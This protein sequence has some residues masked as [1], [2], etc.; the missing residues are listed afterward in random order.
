MTYLTSAV[1]VAMAFQ[2]RLSLAAGEAA[3]EACPTTGTNFNTTAGINYNICPGTDYIGQSSQVIRKINTVEKCAS[4]C[5]DNGRC[6]KATYD[7]AGN[8]CHIKSND[9]DLTWTENKKFDAIYIRNELPETTDIATCPYKET[10]YDAKS[11]DEYFICPGTDLRGNDLQQIEKVDSAT[12]C[13]RQCSTIKACAKAV[14]DTANKVCHVKSADDQNRNTLIWYTNKRYSTIQ[15]KTVYNPATRGKWS[16]LIRLPLI[17]VAAY[18]VPAFPAPERML[19]FSSFREF[20]FTGATGKTQFGDLNLNTGEV[21]Q[22]EVANTHHDMFCPAIATLGDGRIVVQGGS[23][24]EAVS[25]YNPETNEFTRGPNMTVAR[26]YQASCTLSDGRIFTIGGSYSGG[27]GGKNGE[28]FDADTNEWTYLPGAGVEAMLTDDVAGIWRKD[29][30]GW[31]LGWKNGTVFQAGP[32]KAQNWYGTEGRGSS[33]KA[34][35]RDDADAMCGVWAMYDAMAG[36]IFSAVGTPD[37]TDSDANNRAHITT[38]G[39]PWEPSTVERMPDPAYARGFANAVVLPDGTILVTGGQKRSMVFTDTDGIMY[40]EL[41]DPARRTWAQ[42]APE[43]VPR[44]YHS[45]SILLPDATVFSGGGGLC[46][47]KSITADDSGC[48]RTVDHPDGQIFSPP[49]LFNEDGSDATRPTIDALSATNA[50][51]GATI[52]VV[53]QNEEVAG[54]SSLVLVRLGSVTHST[55]TD[56]RRVPLL[57]VTNTGTQVAGEVAADGTLVDFKPIGTEYTVVLPED[58]GVL[59]PG[60]YYLFALS[61]SGVPSVAKTLQIVL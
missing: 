59:L 60:F 13:A 56:Q 6:L 47:V 44:N 52:K 19:F 20:D 23:N 15:R 18:I 58:Y 51:A 11:G 1:A 16:D 43:A 27:R 9:G 14:F 57:N 40:P 50:T 33:L 55:N 36:K 5:A 35:V 61:F 21:S 22:R 38:I 28:V 7:S 12:D 31:L 42:M 10:T 32:S 41:F 39:E 34:G 37:Y 4:L 30:H 46:W 17:P 45:V 48:D 25:I 53:V 54:N 24:A 49:Y 26:G 29:N 3:L 2:F 8:V